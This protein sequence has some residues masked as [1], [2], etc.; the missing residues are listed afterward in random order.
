MFQTYTCGLGVVLQGRITMERSERSVWTSNNRHLTHYIQRSHSGIEQY[1]GSHRHHRSTSL[2]KSTRVAEGY[3]TLGQSVGHYNTITGRWRAKCHHDLIQ[4]AKKL[5]KLVKLHFQL[6]KGH[7]GQEGNERADKLAEKGKRTRTRMGSAAMVPLIGQPHT[8]TSQSSLVTQLQEAAKQTF[9]PKASNKCKP[10][11]SEHTLDLLSQARTAEANGSSEAKQKRNQAKRSARKDRIKWIH[12]QLIA[13]P[14]AEQAPLWRTVRRQKQGFRGRKGKLVVGGQ[15][16]PW[17]STHKAFR[18][19]LQNTQW[20]PNRVSPE[21]HSELKQKRPPRPQ[22]QDHS[23]FAMKE[24]TEALNKLKKRRA[25]GPDHNAN[26]LFL[27]FD[28]DNL[29]VLLTHYNEIWSSGDVPNNWKKAIVVSIYKGKGADTD[30]ANYRP[31]SLLNTIY[32]IFASMLQTRL[33]QE[34]DSHLRDTQLGTSSCNNIHLH[35]PCRTAKFLL[36]G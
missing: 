14:R 30:P 36:S 13:D 10:W 34:H 5:S 9:A 17:S 24:L 1:W 21:V 26:E 4:L 35:S 28:D 27:L 12:D 25:P 11:I 2:C 16:I 31:I 29:D 23:P 19:H 32:K 22:S 20:A 6:V 15:P 7:A 3:N 33:A 8:S 18:D